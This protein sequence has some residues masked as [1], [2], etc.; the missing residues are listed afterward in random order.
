MFS[1]MLNCVEI[2]GV[3]HQMPYE[4]MVAAAGLNI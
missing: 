4:V 2:S 1:E 3:T